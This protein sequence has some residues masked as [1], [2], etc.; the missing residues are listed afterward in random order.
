MIQ[1]VSLDKIICDS[2]PS[3]ITV[4][5]SQLSVLNGLY[6]IIPDLGAPK[7]LF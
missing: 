5:Y 1:S 4:I 7:N 3:G 6:L 2:Y